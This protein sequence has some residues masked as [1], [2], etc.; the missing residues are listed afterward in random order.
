LISDNEE[1]F[2]TCQNRAARQTPDHV[3][4]LPLKK[5]S[6]SIPPKFVE[7]VQQHILPDIIL[8]QTAS[9]LQEK[10]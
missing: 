3:T 9:T 10:N 6:F 4:K 2:S 8:K 1:R 5:Y 7:Q